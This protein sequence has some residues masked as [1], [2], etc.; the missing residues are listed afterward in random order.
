MKLLIIE[1]PAVGVV[2]GVQ[3]GVPMICK[4]PTFVVEPESREDVAEATRLFGEL[5]EAYS[6]EE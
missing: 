5:F 6:K 3:D 4:Y 2:S 1:S